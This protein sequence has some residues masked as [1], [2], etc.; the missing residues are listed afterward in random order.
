MTFIIMTLHRNDD[1]LSSSWPLNPL[2]YWVF[3]KISRSFLFLLLFSMPIGSSPLAAAAAASALT[4]YQT[5]LQPD[6]PMMTMT[7]LKWSTICQMWFDNSVWEMN[8]NLS[9]NPTEFCWLQFQFSLFAF[10]T[11][12]KIDKHHYET[13]P[14]LLLL[15]LW[16]HQTHTQT[17][18]TTWQNLRRINFVYFKFETLWNKTTS[19]WFGSKTTT[20]S[21]LSCLEW[22]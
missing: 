12:F 14:L 13:P 10:M 21:R 2:F 16:R 5:M 3:R 20:L 1:P 15:F 9:Q 6:R 7:L 8:F 11:T 22:S 4:H 18:V 17:H 19:F